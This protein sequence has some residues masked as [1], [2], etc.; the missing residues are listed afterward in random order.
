MRLLLAVSVFVG[1]FVNEAFATDR[2]RL[3]FGILITN[4]TLG[5]GEDRWR[6]GSVATS[7]V[8]G[9]EWTG[10]LPSGFGNILELRIGGEIISPAN[11]ARPQAGDRP[12]AGALSFGL[13]TH[14]QRQG[15]EMSVGGDLVVTGPV[16]RLDELQSGI[17]DLININQPSNRVKDAQVK[18][19]VHLTLVFETGRT[20]RFSQD[21][22]VRPFVEARVGAETLVRG[23]FDLTIGQLGQQEMLVRDPTTGH[24]YRTISADWDGYA[25]VLGADIAHVT[26]STFFPDDQSAVVSD[27]RERVRMGVQ[28]QNANGAHAFYGLTWLGEEFEGQSQG[29]VVGSLRFRLNF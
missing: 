4:D 10:S 23:G 2:T 18:N 26:D 12:Y 21:V 8:W 29:Q 7:R 1:V 13:H 20:L 14:F 28:W 25:V 22:A 11:I 15:Y 17:H 19:G 5:D 27:R 24:R 9:P 6:T 3:G 16:T